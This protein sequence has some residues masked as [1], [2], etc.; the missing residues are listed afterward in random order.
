[1]RIALRVLPFYEAVCTCVVTNWADVRACYTPGQ[2]PAVR[3][4]G[5]THPQLCPL[6]L[7]PQDDD[8]ERSNLL[9]HRNDDGGRIRVDWRQGRRRPPAAV[10]FAEGSTAKK[11]LGILDDCIN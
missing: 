6:A 10:D 8:A 11:N 9:R 2:G 4:A 3:P 5:M 1:V 7:Q